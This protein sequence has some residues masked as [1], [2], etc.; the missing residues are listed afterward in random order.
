MTEQEQ[1]YESAHRC[2]LRLQKQFDEMYDAYFRDVPDNMLDTL[3]T[4]HNPDFSL[5]HCLRW[6]LSALDEIIEDWEN[7]V[8]MADAKDRGYGA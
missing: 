5:Q 2:L 7:V 1:A 8:R 6:G 4:Y 3:L